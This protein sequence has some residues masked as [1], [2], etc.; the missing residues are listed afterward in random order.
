MAYGLVDAVKGLIRPAA[1]WMVAVPLGQLPLSIVAF[2]NTEPGG[3]GGGGGG[4]GAEAIV[5]VLVSALPDAV[6]IRR[7]LPLV[8][9]AV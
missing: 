7:K 5:T 8:A 1:H 2:H 6:A 3:G 4:G 9:P